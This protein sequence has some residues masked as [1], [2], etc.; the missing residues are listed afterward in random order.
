MRS[1]NSPL[2]LLAALAPAAL[3]APALNLTRRAPNP[4]T[5]LPQRATADDL[6]WQPSLDFDTDGC[7]NVPAIDAQGNIAQGLPYEWT[8][9]ATDCHDPS[10][11]DNNNVYSRQRCNGDWCAYL[12]G[13]YFEKDVAVPYFTGPL[14]GH[15]HDWEHIQ[16]WVRRS[17]DTAEFV[18]ASQHGNYEVR[19]AADVRWDGEH[20]KMVYHKDGVS[21]HCFRFANEEDDAIE[22]D[23][24]VWFRGALVSYNG[25]PS[26]ELRE[27]LFAHDFGEALIDFRDDTFAGALTK[28]KDP[29][30]VFDVN[31]DDG[32]PGTP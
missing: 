1:Q 24:G 4:P 14:A 29:S 32:S 22:N 19:A 2:L 9:L 31:V 27:E 8:G 17:T 15:T 18:A 26:A 5:A 13:Y 21:T 3:A 20:P 23:K 7:Y 6:R 25:F 30:I 28:G 16:V 12:Y 11:L 10:D